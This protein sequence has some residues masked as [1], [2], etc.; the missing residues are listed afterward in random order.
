MVSE[1]GKLWS[2]K[3]LSHSQPSLPTLLHLLSSKALILQKLRLLGPILKLESPSRTSILIRAQVHHDSGTNSPSP[4]Q[5]RLGSGHPKEGCSLTG[6]A[7]CD[8]KV[9]CR[10]MVKS[11]TLSKSSTSPSQDHTDQAKKAPGRRQDSR[12]RNPPKDMDISR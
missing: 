2:D 9:P 1:H 11:Q 7:E 5:L 4:H 3:E 10:I 12:V 8:P 6:K